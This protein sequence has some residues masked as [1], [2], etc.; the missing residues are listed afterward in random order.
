MLDNLIQR[1]VPGRFPFNSLHVMQPMY[2]RKMNE[3]IA[4]DMG[5]IELYTLDGLKAPHRLVVV[6]SNRS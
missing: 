2:T 3:Q 1:G 6:R 5:T 4:R